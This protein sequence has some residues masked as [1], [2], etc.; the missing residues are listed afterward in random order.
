MSKTT[1]TFY[2]I[3][4]GPP[5]RPFAPNPWKI[6]Y[7]L[8]RPKPTSKLEAS[9]RIVDALF[10]LFSRYT[11]NLKRIHCGLQYETSWVDVTKVTEVRKSLGAAPVR[12][13]WIDNSDFYTLPVL[14]DHATGQTVGDSFDIALYLEK[15]Y[16][17]P[18]REQGEV[19]VPQLFPPSTIALQRAF[20]AHVD[21]VF[22]NHVILVTHT[23]PLNHET[24]D[25][26]KTECCR[27]AGKTSWEELGL[28]GEARAAMLTKF[29]AALGELAKLY[30]KRDEGTFL[31]GRTILYADLIVGGWLQMM[32]V[33]LPEW[34]ELRGWQD[35]L[36]GN[37][38]DALD[39]YAQTG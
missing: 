20:N 16:P 13:H 29:E 26:F 14:V 33:C 10:P 5:L 9:P 18:S 3:A 30:N 27:R 39:K 25:P 19:G 32:K 23:M 31:E 28:S 36:W 15:T 22:S 21:T 11:L 17:N 4:S 1:I 24:A 7:V 6:R 2:D 35:G 8:P 38:S 34:E 37:L 12:K